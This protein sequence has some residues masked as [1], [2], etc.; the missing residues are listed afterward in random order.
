MSPTKGRCLHIRLVWLRPLLRF[1]QLGLKL[2]GESILCGKSV[3]D[4][5]KVV[6]KMARKLNIDGKYEWSMYWH[7]INLLL[8]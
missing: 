8:G 4:Q 6:I 5:V 2:P 3:Q 7:N 1:V